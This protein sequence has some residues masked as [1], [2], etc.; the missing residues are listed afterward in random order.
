[1]S[2][3]NDSAGNAYIELPT[4]KDEKVR[5]TFV[6]ASKAGYHVDAVRINIIQANGRVRHPGP[7][8]PV[9]YL[10]A[11]FAAINRLRADQTK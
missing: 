5:A 7:E 4:L 3:T 6:P 8:I 9:Q 11:F 2:I 10:D 1:M